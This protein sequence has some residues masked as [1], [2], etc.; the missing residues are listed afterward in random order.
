MCKGWERFWNSNTQDIRYAK[1]MLYSEPY[2]L[3]ERERRD[4][5]NKK[6]LP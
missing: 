1:K 5:N 6:I 4:Y 3:Q 2:P